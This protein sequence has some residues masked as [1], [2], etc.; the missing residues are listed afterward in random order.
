VSAV[1]GRVF[2]GRVDR[3]AIDANREEGAVLYPVVLSVDNPDTSLLPGMTARVRMQVARVDNVLA[4]HEAALRY[5]PE[6]AGPASPRSR[7]WKRVSPGEIEPVSVRTG[8]SD[9]VYTEIQVLNGGELKEGDALA[10]GLLHPE[11]STKPNVSL[12]GK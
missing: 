11:S 10:V 7:V 12:G 4:V 8:V 2:H 5:T 1:P 6:G 9:G 3:V